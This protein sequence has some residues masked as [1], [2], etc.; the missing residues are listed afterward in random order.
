VRPDPRPES[1]AL[2]V[3]ATTAIG[4]NAFSL[5]QPTPVMVK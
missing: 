4:L 1:F 3:T 2:T 5:I